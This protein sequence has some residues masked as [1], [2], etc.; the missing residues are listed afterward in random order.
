MIWNEEVAELAEATQRMRNFAQLDRELD[1]LLAALV[2]TS[3][4]RLA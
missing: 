3:S 4:D 1:G 2:G